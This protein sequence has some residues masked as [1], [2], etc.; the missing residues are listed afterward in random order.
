MSIAVEEE[1]KP[2]E[3]VMEVCVFCRQPTRYWYKAND[4]ACCPRCARHAQPEDVPTKKE[5]CRRE[6]IVRLSRKYAL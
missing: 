3:P 5:W 2:H 1:P 4:V 6:D